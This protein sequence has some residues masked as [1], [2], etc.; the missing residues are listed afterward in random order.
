MSEWDRI[1]EAVKGNPIGVVAFALLVILWAEL[2]VL[3][4]VKKFLGLLWL[5]DQVDLAVARK[6]G[7]PVDE[8][9]KLLRSSGERAGA[10]VGR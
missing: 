5:H 3:P 7:V 4:I 1:L 6:V 9:D 2:R 8:I 10:E